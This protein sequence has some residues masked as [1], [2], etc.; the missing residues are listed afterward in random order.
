MWFQQLMGFAEQSPDQVRSQIDLDGD[1]LVSKVNQHRVAWGRLSTPSLAEL[2]ARVPDAAEG[3]ACTVDEVV[4]DVKVLHQDPANAGAL[5]Q[6][7]SQFNLLEM[8]GPSV[9]PEQGVSLY[10][11]DH[12]QGPACAIACGGGTIYRN[13]FAPVNGGIGQTADRQIDCLEE[14]QQALGGSDLWQMR[15]GYAQPTP[16]SLT[17]ARAALMGL[18]DAAL[19]V[20]RGHLRVGVQHDVEVIGP[21]HR[22]SQVYASAM[23][24]AY[25]ALPKEA[26]APVARLV[27]EAAYEATLLCARAEG[28]STVFLT[29]LGGGAFGNDGS[30]IVHACLRA[31]RRVH[32]LDVRIVSYGSSSPLAQQIV[33]G[34]G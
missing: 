32:G 6:A 15:N 25:T 19:D 27:L 14:L 7:A 29:L 4:G 34:V 3:A 30:W 2:R 12:T 18:D 9:T 23:P 24:V 10:D 21:G 13:Y 26:W 11:G 17:K 28:I 20:L 31:L 8:V 22:V 5:F 1:C 16:T 33:G